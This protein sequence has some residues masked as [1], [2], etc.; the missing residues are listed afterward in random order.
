MKL[1]KRLRKWLIGIA[2]VILLSL[3]ALVIWNA[4]VFSGLSRF[5][6]IAF[7]FPGA[8]DSAFD[9]QAIAWDERAEIFFFSGYMKNKTACPVY[10]VSPGKETRRVSLLRA[11]GS[12]LVTHAGGIAISGDYFYVADSV[13]ECLVVFS[14]QEILSARDGDGVRSI[15]NFATAVSPDDGI[16][17]SFITAADGKLYVGEYHLPL[18]PVFSQRR[19]H[20][21]GSSY[22]IMAAFS[23]DPSKPLGLAEAPCEAYCLPEAVQGAVFDNSGRIFLSRCVFLFPSAI[24]AWQPSVSGQMTLMGNEVPVYTLTQTGGVAFVPLSEQIELVDGKL[25]VATEACAYL[26]SWIYSMWDW[27]KCRAIDLSVFEATPLP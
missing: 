11:N 18:L 4:V 20:H 3:L 10:L 12:P 7:D 6:E 24:D 5:S 19:N 17:P 1:L 8:E 13:D 14:R 25:Y 23:V 26:P 16:K 2:A 27:Q 15:G 22:A 9:L 21:I